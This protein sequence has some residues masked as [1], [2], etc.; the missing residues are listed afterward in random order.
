MEMNVSKS[1]RKRRHKHHDH[2]TELETQDDLSINEPRF[3]ISDVAKMYD[4]TPQY[5]NLFIEKGVLTPPRDGVYRGKQIHSLRVE[6]VE[7]IKLIAHLKKQGYR[8]SEIIERVE[9]QHKYRQL[10][11]E[12]LPLINQGWENPNWETL[13]TIM[14]KLAEQL[15]DPGKTLV[16]MRHSG[17]WLEDMDFQTE[18]K[19]ER[20]PALLRETY[21]KIGY[22]LC[23]MLEETIGKT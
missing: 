18:V 17:Y 16:S 8:I 6:D 21:A 10:G 23:V 1:Q 4:L 2:Q 12:L 11:K 22:A 13:K 15:D 3:R 5:I 7:K 20:M 9:N 14:E 19:E